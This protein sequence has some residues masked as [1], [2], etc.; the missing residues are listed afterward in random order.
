MMQLSYPDE[1]NDILWVK[2]WNPQAG[3][4]DQIEATD[5]LLWVAHQ[6]QGQIRLSLL[7]SSSQTG[8]SIVD[9]PMALARSIQAMNSDDLSYPMQLP[10]SQNGRIARVYAK[11]LQVWIDDLGWQ[12][13]VGGNWPYDAQISAYQ[14]IALS[15]ALA[16]EEATSPLDFIVYLHSLSG[17][18]H[19]WGNRHQS[20][21]LRN[22][23]FALKWNDF[24]SNQSTLPSLLY[25]ER[26][27]L[28]DPQNN[29]VSPGRFYSE[30]SDCNISESAD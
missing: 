5:H 14:P 4:F 12:N 23:F 2:K 6:R 26:Y 17:N 29:V 18:S 15:I 8:I 30:Y 9:P 22:N 28:V 1:I 25:V 11:R 24:D 20:A 13:A 7:K 19:Y 27:Q 3:V 21:V 10:V 16:R